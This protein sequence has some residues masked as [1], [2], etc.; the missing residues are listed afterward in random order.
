[1]GDRPMTACA[2]H[3]SLAAPRLRRLALYLEHWS[4][5]ESSI[6]ACACI[7]DAVRLHQQRQPQ[8]PG[9][10][11]RGGA[12]WIHHDGRLSGRQRAAVQ[13]EAVQRAR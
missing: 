5:N 1:M 8:S 12:A 4:N 13:L 7:S 6:C 10:D 3:S 2:R 9:E 11:H